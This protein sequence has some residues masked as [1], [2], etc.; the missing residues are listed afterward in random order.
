MHPAKLLFLKPQYMTS[1]LLV[2]IH[3][4]VREKEVLMQSSIDG[5]T[6]AGRAFGQADAQGGAG[7][8][9]RFTGNSEGR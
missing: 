2:R 6:G 9:G 4:F 1:G 3:T 8:N 5:N 7:Y